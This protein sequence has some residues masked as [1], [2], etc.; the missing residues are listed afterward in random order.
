SSNGW[1][2]GA[3]A[4]DTT[5]FWHRIDVDT[6]GFENVFLNYSERRS[7]TGI[8][9][10]AVWYSTD[11]GSSFTS[12]GTFANPDD[13]NTRPRSH[14]MSAITA[15]NDNANVVFLINGYMAE[16]S[17]GT[18]RQESISIDA[19]VIPPMGLITSH[20]GDGSGATV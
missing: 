3:S 7:G 9:E 11:G 12:F 16:A 4:S 1:D 18:W 6:S 19:D 13:T 15:L 10:H 14:D 5:G 8:R 2:T 17:G 20:T